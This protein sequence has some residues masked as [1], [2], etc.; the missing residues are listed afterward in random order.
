MTEIRMN[1][2]P[3]KWQRELH[4]SNAKFKVA[5][6]HRRGGKS[7]A[8]V[9]ELLMQGVKALADPKINNVKMLYVAPIYAMAKN[10]AWDELRSSTKD[11]PIGNGIIKSYNVSDLVFK[12][13]T[14]DNNFTIHLKGSD[15]PDTLR[16]LGTYYI[17]ID[18]YQD[19]KTDLWTKVLY[20]TTL[21]YPDSKVLFIGTPKGTNH[22]HTL[23]KQAANKP[24]WETF[25][26][27][28]TKT[29]KFPADDTLPHS[30]EWYYDPEHP[31]RLKG[32]ITTREDIYTETVDEHGPEAYEQEFMCSWTPS[33][34]G[35]IYGIQMRHVRETGRLGDYSVDN[36]VPVNTAWD[37][38]VADDMFVLAYQQIG[39]EIRVVKE[40]HGHGKGIDHFINELNK[41]REQNGLAF[42]YHTA[43]HDIKVREASDGQTRHSKAMKLGFYFSIL[44]KLRIEEGI[45]AARTL[46]PRCK[47]DSMG[48]ERI[49]EDLSLYHYEYDSKNDTFKKQPKHDRHSHGADAFR[50]LALGIQD[51]SVPTVEVLGGSWNGNPYEY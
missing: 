43:P 2:T 23:F 5:V 41:W 26:F 15:K 7:K 48:C 4:S 22:F 12:Y 17:V 34:R 39:A 50:Y 1:Y 45:Q 40:W 37:I 38:G 30:R 27:P 29:D 49:V 16:G 11:W 28:I 44:P 19:C 32:K 6:V 47:F 3:Y 18:E 42:G 8:A 24:K 10:I 13:G 35:A 31:E 25:Y 14:E 36:R 51:P 20:P 21:D 33:T 46:L 9:M